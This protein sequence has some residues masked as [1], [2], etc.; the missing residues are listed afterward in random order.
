[1]SPCR[2][3]RGRTVVSAVGLLLLLAGLGNAPAAS[4]A[5]SASQ[6]PSSNFVAS[7][8][9]GSAL[10][11]APWSGTALRS[12]QVQG[13]VADDTAEEIAEAIRTRIQ[14]LNAESIRRALSIAH[15]RLPGG[16][17][18]ARIAVAEGSMVDLLLVVHGEPLVESVDVRGVPEDVDNWQAQVL[19]RPGER[20]IENRLLRTVYQLEDAIEAAGY[21]DAGV[22]LSV[23]PQ[24][25]QRMEVV[26]EVKPGEQVLVAEAT[27]DPA[28]PPGV[29]ERLPRLNNEVGKPFLRGKLREDS[30][31]LR[32]HLV[33]AD[34]RQARVGEPVQQRD[35]NAVRL[36]F[37]VTSGP[38]MSIEFVGFDVD[39]L[40]RQNRLPVLRQQG[41]DAALIPATQRE[42]V[43]FMQSKGYYDAAVTVETEDQDGR[44]NVRFVLEPGSRLELKEVIVEGAESF[45][46]K[47]LQD[48]MLTEQGRFLVDSE[49]DDDI[50]NLRSFYAVQGFSRAEIESEVTR[51][52]GSLSVA[53]RVGEGPRSVVESVRVDGVEQ[54]ER[55][56][57]VAGLPIQAGSPFHENVVNAGAAELQRRYRVLGY[58]YSFVTTDT[59]HVA[60]DPYRFEVVYRVLEGKRVEVGEVILKGLGRT[61]PGFLRKVMGL[62]PGYVLSDEALVEAESRLFQLGLF[63]EVDVYSSP[64]A[65]FVDTEDVVVE[66]TEAPIHR[67]SYGLGW[68]SQDGL[69][70][71]VGYVRNNWLGRG[72]AWNLDASVSTEEELYRILLTQPWVGSHRTPVTYSLFLLEE[73]RESFDLKQ[74]GAQVGAR[75][76]RGRTTTGLLF[77]WRENETTRGAFNLDPD[78]A[79][80]EIASVAPSMFVDRRDDAFN[81]SQGWSGLVEIE[82][83]FSLFGTE[84]RFT[85]LFG[86]FTRYFDLG[87]AGVLA[88]AVRAGWI[89]PISTA[90]KGPDTGLVPPDLESSEV[91]ISERFMAGGRSSHRAYGRLELG[92]LGETLLLCDDLPREDRDCSTGEVLPLGGAAMGILN[93]DWR[94]PVWG[95]LGGVLFADAGNVWGDWSHADR[96]KVGAGVGF[97]YATPVGPL[98]LEVAWKLDRE[99]FED[100]YVVV[101][102]VGNPF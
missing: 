44:R 67:L 95:E 92:E 74:S 75:Q 61:Q 19:V 62:K 66:V 52:D 98:R 8:G 16:D 34:Y 59:I 102:S 60:E 38:L 65:P 84:E 80:V 90:G 47:R 97:R 22:A 77:T 83:A 14:T 71:L 18:E 32:R 1:M 30:E 23:N 40:R 96:I 86:E 28:L 45:E 31:R 99:P 93:L 10:P 64:S 57:I 41:Y 54:V 13:D 100:P 2:I 82:Q 5:P 36:T 46:E 88:G 78:T 70:G 55:Q 24:G 50:A 25:R 27:M 6:E 81:P 20:L 35:G 37:P 73:D 33:E 39:R 17:I 42:L 3:N 72:L 21:L 58:R 87:R 79:P 63:S 43:N 85:K 48:L 69:R 91:H 101:I 15:S 49:L 12:V 89:R 68:D 56:D 29:D 26:F 53:I 11:S 4:A 9:F 7:G 76:Q 51:A 94:F